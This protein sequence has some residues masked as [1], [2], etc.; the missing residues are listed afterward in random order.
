MDSVQVFFYGTN[1]PSP[2]GAQ[3]ISRLDRAP[4]FD[5]LTAGD[6]SRDKPTTGGFA[7]FDSPQDR[8]DEGARA[9]PGSSGCLPKRMVL[10]SY[11]DEHYIT[12]ESLCQEG[13]TWLIFGK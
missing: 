3:L 1:I 11:D 9:A 4:C 2:G 7:S 10:L 8:Q 5:K 12:E 6:S 13:N